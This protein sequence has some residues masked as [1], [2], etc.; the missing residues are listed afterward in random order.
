[1]LAAAA[2]GALTGCGNQVPINPDRPT[3]G[4]AVPEVAHL[5]RTCGEGGPA[6]MLTVGW[7]TCDGV[8]T[9]TNPSYLFSIGKTDY[10][11]IQAG[12]SFAMVGDMHAPGFGYRITGGTADAPI[13]V[14]TIAKAT[15]TPITAGLI[16][17]DTF[18]ADREATGTYE[19]TY[20]GGAAHGTF[21]AD[22][23]RDM[24]CIP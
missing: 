12:A 13:T 19:V 22:F 9:L 7:S 1:M 15:K 21:T 3:P 16:K 18:E 4:A 6:M 2:S 8:A 17:F 5:T 11:H 23:C 14:S 20:P 24:A 10:P